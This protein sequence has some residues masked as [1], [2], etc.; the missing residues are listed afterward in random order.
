M[1]KF[2][3]PKGG[4]EVVEVGLNKAKVEKAEETLLC[5]CDIDIDRATISYFRSENLSPYKVRKC[6]RSYERVYN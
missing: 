4:S 6:T 3:Y 2:V 5:C 1:M